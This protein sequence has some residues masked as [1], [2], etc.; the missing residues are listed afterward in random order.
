MMV[1]TPPKSSAEKQLRVIFGLSHV[2]E[3][4]KPGD[5]ESSNLLLPLRLMLESLGFE[6]SKPAV[7]DGAWLDRL[8]DKFG[9]KDFPRTEHFSSFARATLVENINPVELPDAALM[10]WM[11]HEE[12]LFRIY[13][14]HFVMKRL[15]VGFGADSDGVDAFISYSLSVQNRRKSRVGHAFEGHIRH[16]FRMHQL[17]F[18]QGTKALVTENNARPDFLFPSFSA[19][20]DK[21][22]PTEKLIM[23]GA[24]TTCKDR[25]RQILS[26]AARINAK[27]LITLEP[28]ISESQTNEM[29]DH[30]LQLVIPSAIH[31]TFS[32]GQQARLLDV[33][34]FISFVKAK[35][36]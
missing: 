3:S 7:D 14:R 19:Y 22:F 2:D 13:E 18:E 4:F 36:S 26:E 6:L 28:A 8:L 23:L 5:L 21:S 9:D 17:K 12:K 25:W 1:F 34:R 15:E 11:D 29:F 20:H 31:A 16:L 30:K 32:E 27:H 33:N 10:A 24:K 35:Q